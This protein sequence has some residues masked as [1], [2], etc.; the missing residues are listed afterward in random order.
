ME[1]LEKK[2]RKLERKY[3]ILIVY[4]LLVTLIYMYNTFFG[5]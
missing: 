1:E 2:Y 4:L 5:N 3:N